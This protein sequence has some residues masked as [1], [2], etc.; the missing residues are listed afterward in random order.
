M[1]YKLS[2]HLFLV[3]IFIY[4]IFVLSLV[5]DGD[6]F[7]DFCLSHCDHTSFDIMSFY[8][9]SPIIVKRMMRSTCNVQN[10][11]LNNKTL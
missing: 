9:I 1:L 7:L 2:K 6:P 4:R 3:A 10:N 5:F 11:Q 8:F